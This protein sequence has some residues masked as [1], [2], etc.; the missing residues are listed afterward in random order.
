[1][2]NQSLA[3]FNPIEIFRID[4][5]ILIE[6]LGKCHRGNALNEHFELSKKISQ[7]TLYFYF[8]HHIFKRSKHKSENSEIVFTQSQYENFK[9]FLQQNYP[10]TSAFRYLIRLHGDNPKY[11]L[12]L[13]ENNQGITRYYTHDY[14]MYGDTVDC[15]HHLLEIFVRLLG[16]K[17]D[18][19]Y[20]PLGEL[21]ASG[22]NDS[23]G[24]SCFH[25]F[26]TRELY[27][28]RILILIHQF[29]FDPNKIKDFDAFGEEFEEDFNNY[30]DEH[31]APGPEYAAILAMANSDNSD[32]ED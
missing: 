13:L 26:L 4:A 7:G 32:N 16:E 10:D 14:G 27:D 6:K 11:C 5:Q 19:G 22:L 3:T 2:F 23:E 21:V 29:A 9:L 31:L 8:S 18:H 20:D 17:V 12:I 30:R 15:H 28:P 1:M 24:N 25:T